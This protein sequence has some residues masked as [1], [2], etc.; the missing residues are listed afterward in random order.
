MSLFTRAA[1]AAT[2][3]HPAAT[4]DEQDALRRKLRRNAA[5]T[6]ASQAQAL[7]GRVASHATALLIRLN[8]DADGRVPLDEAAFQAAVAEARALRRELQTLLAR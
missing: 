4:A 5:L 3:A 7:A 2:T 6:D 1:Q 8:D